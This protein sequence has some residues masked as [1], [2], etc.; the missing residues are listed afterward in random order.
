MTRY[1]SHLTRWY[2]V[3]N[4]SLIAFGAIVAIY[5]LA[6]VANGL[7]TGVIKSLRRHSHDLVRVDVDPDW[8]GFNVGVRTLMAALFAAAAVFLW[9]KLRSEMR[10]GVADG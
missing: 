4:A 10:R 5:N 9:R 1:R 2:I 7:R 6:L 8:F 3:R